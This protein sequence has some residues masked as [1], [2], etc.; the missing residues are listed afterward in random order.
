MINFWPEIHGTSS[1]SG[2]SKILKSFFKEININKWNLLAID[3][4]LIL[5]ALNKMKFFTNKKVL[6]IKS[7]NTHTVGSKYRP[8]NKKFWSRRIQQISY[9]E[10]LSNKKIFNMDKVFSKLINFFSF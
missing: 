4:L 2:H 6:T 3:A 7:I 1:L 8:I 9:W 10:S 5:Y